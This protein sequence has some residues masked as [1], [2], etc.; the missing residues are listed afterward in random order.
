MKR[1]STIDTLMSIVYRSKINSYYS[2][3]YLDRDQDYTI[4]CFDTHLAVLFKTLCN[5]HFNKRLLCFLKKNIKTYPAYSGLLLS[6]N[7]FHSPFIIIS[8]F[9]SDKIPFFIS[10]YYA[11]SVERL[12]VG[13]RTVVD[14]RHTIS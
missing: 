5:F 9:I 7:T 6:L 8:F 10:C 4:H 11:V 2:Q 1:E 13:T 14:S 3:G 12:Y